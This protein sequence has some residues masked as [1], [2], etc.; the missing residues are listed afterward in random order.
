[1]PPYNEHLTRDIG[2]L[3]LATAVLLGA[4]AWSLRR[5]FVGSAL[6]AWL[7]F[8]APHAIW[9]VFNVDPYST[10]DAVANL[11]TLASTVFLPAALLI[12]L[13]RD[14]PRDQLVAEHGRSTGGRR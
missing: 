2:A 6:I 10:G 14:R 8:A 13:A 5:T 1:L 3:Y 12:L 9:H 7:A 4:A 11:V